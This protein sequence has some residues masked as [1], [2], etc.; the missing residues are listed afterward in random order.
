MSSWQCQH[1]LTL[2]RKIS[3]QN[4]QALV[5]VLFMLYSKP[6]L[7]IDSTPPIIQHLRKN[8]KSP[9]SVALFQVGTQ[10]AT[11]AVGGWAAF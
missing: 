8:G 1:F 5:I 3:P 4:G 7:S 2:K 11:V 9:F 10:S 6:Q